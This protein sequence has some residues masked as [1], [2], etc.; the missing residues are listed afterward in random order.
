MWNFIC[1]QVATDGTRTSLGVS[2][3]W[4]EYYTFAT[5]KITLRK[6]L[7]A[8]SDQINTFAEICHKICWWIT[9]QSG[10]RGFYEIWCH[11]ELCN[12]PEYFC[13]KSV[14]SARFVF[15]LRWIF[16]H[17][18]KWL[19]KHKINFLQFSSQSLHLNPS[20]ILC[21][22]SKRSIDIC[23]GKWSNIPQP[24]FFC[25]VKFKILLIECIIHFIYW[26]CSF[27]GRVPIIQE[28]ALDQ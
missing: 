9:D 3:Q 12:V 19:Y 27:S 23:K 22:E 14:N 21:S 11:Y 10:S 1:T 20:E 15:G 2:W 6:M 26:F 7:V 24:V 28:L 8:T 16:Q 25:T 4:T 17:R 18:N 13:Q 5:S